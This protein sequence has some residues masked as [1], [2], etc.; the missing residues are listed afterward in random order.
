MFGFILPALIAPS[1]CTRLHAALCRIFD[2]V[3]FDGLSIRVHACGRCTASKRK[4]MPTSRCNC[5]TK[6][7]RTPYRPYAVFDC[8]FFSR[9]LEKMWFLGHLLVPK[10]T[11]CREGP[12]HTQ[13]NKQFGLF[14]HFSIEPIVLAKTSRTSM[15]SLRGFQEV[16]C[17]GMWG[18]RVAKWQLR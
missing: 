18:R 14:F 11:Y 2:V 1:V 16:E 10:R 6:S 7:V 13:K 9:V 8:I 17:S 4:C 12:L 5:G 15:W 3:P